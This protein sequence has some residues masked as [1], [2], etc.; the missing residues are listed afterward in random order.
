MELLAISRTTL[1][2]SA[3]VLSGFVLFCGSVLLLLA[4]I[5]GLRMGYLMMA[6][7]LFAFMIVLSALWS[8]GA[9]GT[10]AFLGPKGELPHWVALGEGPALTSSTHPVIAQYPGGPWV[11]PPETT[12]VTT[13]AEGDEGGLAAEV[14]AASLVLQE[15]LADEANSEARRAGVE[16]EILP[17]DFEVTDIRFATV[18]DTELAA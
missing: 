8:F 10:P 13:V 1:E 7:G 6:T 4:A 9:P 5:F 16:G 11:A 12:E 18:G 17:E 14:E 3:A 2:G 15:F